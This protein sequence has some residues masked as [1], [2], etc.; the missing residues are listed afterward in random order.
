[1]ARLKTFAQGMRL[2]P[3]DLNAMQDEYLAG[4]AAPRPVLVAG[5]VAPLSSLYVAPGTLLG[6]PVWLSDSELRAG[7]RDA[8]LRLRLT[9]AVENTVPTAAITAALAPVTMGASQLVAGTPV[10][11]VVVDPPAANTAV[12]RVSTPIATG[13]LDGLFALWLSCAVAQ[14]PNA[15]IG[16]TATLSVGCA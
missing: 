5:Q 2:L 13:A 7:A 6:Q 3:D 12:S 4:L 8:A 15:P 14:V 9:V 1:M 11:S 16:V 10:G